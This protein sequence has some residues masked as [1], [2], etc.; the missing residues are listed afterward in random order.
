L[1]Y[2]AQGNNLNIMLPFLGKDF[3]K[4]SVQ[5][6]SKYLID[7]KGLQKS[8]LRLAFKDKLPRRI[9]TQKSEGFTPPFKLWY[10]KNLEYVT[11]KLIKSKNL[12]ISMDYIKHLIHSYKQANDYALGMKIWLII[13]LVSW[14]EARINP[15]HQVDQL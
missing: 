4:Y 3:V 8:I 2:A 12:G 1:V 9:L 11:K 10:Y 13:N 15:K 5:I 6:P 7:K 14:Q